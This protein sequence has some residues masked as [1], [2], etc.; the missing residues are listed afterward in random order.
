MRTADAAKAQGVDHVGVVTADL[1][2][3][4]A[5]WRRLG[6]S[7][8]ALARHGNNAADGRI[9]PTGTGN[10]CVML[11][12]GY[13]ELIGMVDPNAASATLARFL[14]AYTGIHVLTFAV[15]DAA[16]AQTRLR[17]AGLEADLIVSARPA[18]PADP[19]GPQARFVRLPLTDAD[20]RLQLL[21]HSTPELVWQ[22]R[23]LT[24]PNHAVALEAVIVA[25]ADPAGFAARVSR[26][27]GVAM[28]PD[29]LGGFALRLAQGEVRILPEAALTRVFPGTAAPALPFIAGMILRTD[30]G[31]AAA[32]R[33]LAGVARPAPGGLAAEIGGVAILFAA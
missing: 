3:G 15:A 26:A 4:A 30:D 27:A 19:A 33:L 29:P 7:V 11:R 13:V 20:P 5:A 28:V 10:H 25:A 6:F 1:K 21:Q 17:L 16:A 8:T 14:R 31:N 9:V 18:D 24:H 12:Q 23:F 22:E 32:A 2:S